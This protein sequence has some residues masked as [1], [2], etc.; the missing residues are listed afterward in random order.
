MGFISLFLAKLGKVSHHLLQARGN[1]A[2]ENYRMTRQGNSYSAGWPNINI[3]V[4]ENQK[5]MEVK[6][7]SNCTGIVDYYIWNFGDGTTQKTLSKEVTHT[8]NLLTKDTWLTQSGP[9][10]IPG[11][12]YFAGRWADV[13]LTTHFVGDYGV[14]NNGQTETHSRYAC[15]Y[16][17]TGE[18]YSAYTIATGTGES[19]NWQDSTDS[20]IGIYQDNN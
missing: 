14:G 4:S 11:M 6:F 7:Y 16:E 15:V 19:V 5:R 1:A 8:Y 13:T 2:Y 12:G 17:I 10:P 20:V 9:L 3:A 18:A